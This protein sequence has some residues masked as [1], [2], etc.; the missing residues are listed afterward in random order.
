MLSNGWYLTSA[1]IITANWEADS[2]NRW[3]VPFG[4]DSGKSFMWVN[5][6]LMRR[7]EHITMWKNLILALTGS[8][9]YNCNFSS[10][11]KS[12]D[13]IEKCRTR[14]LRGFKQLY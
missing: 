4:G 11:S 13:N 12:E 8:Y 9:D 3:T 2:D 7:L 10:Q 14:K 5:N 1:P 6:R